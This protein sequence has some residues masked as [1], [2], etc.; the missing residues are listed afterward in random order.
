MGKVRQARSFRA[1]MATVTVTVLGA[2]ALV[3][4]ASGN[5]RPPPAPQIVKAELLTP[6]VDNTNG[7]ATAVIRVWVRDTRALAVTTPN[8]G[9]IPPDWEICAKL[10]GTPDPT[11]NRGDGS[12]RGDAGFCTSWLR[13]GKV[14]ASG[15]DAVF[16]VP[17]AVPSGISLT[18]Q[19]GDT[20]PPGLA[21]GSPRRWEVVARNGSDFG[22]RF[23]TDLSFGPT[24]GRAVGVYPLVGGGST[25]WVGSTVGGLQFRRNGTPIAGPEQRM[26]FLLPVSGT[27][28]YTVAGG[29]VGVTYR[30]ESPLAAPTVRFEPGSA[31]VVGTSTLTATIN[32]GEV[33]TEW[34]YRIDNGFW[35]SNGA[36]G[37]IPVAGL[38]L[39]R[40]TVD[41][42]VNDGAGLL[43]PIVSRSFD[44]VASPST[45]PTPGSIASLFS[46]R[47][48]YLLAGSDGRVYSFSDAGSQASAVTHSAAVVDIVSSADRTGFWTLDAQG[49]VVASGTAWRSSTA[50]SRANWRSGE[51]A[52]ALSPTS[53][54]RGYWVFTS[55]GRVIPFGDAGSLPD[56]LDVTLNAA[57]VDSIVSQDGR[58]VYLVA[59]DGGVFA[60]NTSF[61]GSMGGQ[62]LNQPVRSVLTDPDGSGYWLVAA[63][64]GVFAF[65]APFLSSVPGV[66]RPGQRLNAPVTGIVSSGAGYLLVAEDGGVF[67]FGTA[68]RGSLGSTALSARI[69][70][71]TTL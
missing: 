70:A 21:V 13:A 29:T 28:T 47:G 2:V 33:A 64:G 60:L 17:L 56:L 32:A 38:A 23:G 67:A 26:G 66:L 58:G 11:S 20:I 18:Y 55:V 48:G 52:V 9:A 12:P 19:T 41:V 27:S 15:T 6:R 59:G 34:W 63:D 14:D 46:S 10:E 31:V 4:P 1:A 44:V 16:D 65:D 50:V 3:A 71:I 8:G 5:E 7:V 37:A 39:G 43:S 40:H 45:P 22:L 25:A 62:R 53:S 42:Q 68:F 35:T 61:L 69:V 54:G 36:S 49:G 30:A 51:R 24:T 57:I